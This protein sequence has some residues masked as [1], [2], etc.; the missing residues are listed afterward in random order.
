MLKAD[1]MKHFE[2]YQSVADALE[3]TR[4]AVQQWGEVVPETSAYKLQV[5]TAG[6]VRVDPSLYASSKR[7]HSVTATA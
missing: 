7:T 4:S 6:R 5:I 3:I 2:T 1:V